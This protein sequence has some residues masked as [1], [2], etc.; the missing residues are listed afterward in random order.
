MMSAASGPLR[1]FEEGFGSLNIS[2][3]LEQHGV[4][5]DRRIEVA[6]HQPARS[7]LALDDLRQ[8]NKS[9]L[10]IAGV[11]ELEGLGDAVALND[12]RLQGVI[13]R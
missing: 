6:R 7:F 1:K 2:A 9:E 5:S 8:G 10:G 3:L 4:L 12:L 11:D 13:Q